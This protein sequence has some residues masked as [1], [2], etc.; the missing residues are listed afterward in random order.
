[1]KRIFNNIFLLL[2]SCTVSLA[3]AELALRYYLYIKDTGRRFDL[4]ISTYQKVP[5]SRGYRYEFDNDNNFEFKAFVRYNNKGYRSDFNWRT[6]KEPE[7]FRIAIFGDSYTECETSD[8]SWVDILHNRISNNKELLKRINRKKITVANFGRSGY[9]F[10]QF[11][12]EYVTVRDWFKPDLTVFAFIDE[13]F[14]R[15]VTPVGGL[16]KH[17]NETMAKN[18]GSNRNINTRGYLNIPGFG[19]HLYA[20]PSGPNIFVRSLFYGGSDESLIL[21]KASLGNAKRFLAATVAREKYLK[22]GDCQLF[23]LAKS[24]IMDRVR[25]FSESAAGNDRSNTFLKA[26]YESVQIVGPEPLILVNLPTFYETVNQYN[27]TGP[28][29]EPKYFPQAVLQNKSLQIIPLADF[30]PASA[31]YEQK[32]SWFTLPWDGHPSNQGAEL[33]GSTLSTLLEDYLTYTISGKGKLYMLLSATRAKDFLLLADETKERDKKERQAYLILEDAR[34]KRDEKSYEESLELFTRVLQLAPYLGMPGLLY[35]ERGDIY[36]S[37]GR[38]Q[39]ALNDYKHAIDINPDK[40]FL[41]KHASLAFALGKMDSMAEDI[42]HLK[43]CCM[44][45]TEVKHFFSQL[46]TVKK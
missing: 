3:A 2:I 42:G 23:K 13:D 15:L 43:A 20:V 7:E 1:M 24:A 38:F 46:A 28:V 44:N 5:G 27:K 17:I 41:I 22:S 34:R 33:F 14:E 19:G 26:F 9:G 30:L 31:S 45:E 36:Y 10:Q 12:E 29:R 39:E 21:N 6:E 11:A 4:V 35:V 40:S 8:F 18:Y 32:Y 37:L 16:R 25:T